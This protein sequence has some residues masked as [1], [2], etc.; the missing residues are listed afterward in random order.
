MSHIAVARGLGGD[1]PAFEVAVRVGR[2]RLPHAT[3]GVELSILIC[4]TPMAWK[5]RHSHT[6]EGLAGDLG[7]GPDCSGRAAA[8]GQLCFCGVVYMS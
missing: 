2:A 1:V 4:I 7:P 5:L 6:G 8:L 3:R